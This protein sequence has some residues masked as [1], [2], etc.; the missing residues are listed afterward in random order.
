MLLPVA[1]PIDPGGPA[2]SVHAPYPEAI[3]P[4]HRVEPVSGHRSDD[5]P[6]VEI[7]IRHRTAGAPAGTAAQAGHDPRLARWAPVVEALGEAELAIVGFLRSMGVPASEAEDTARRVS[8]AAREQISAVPEAAPEHYEA[9]RLSLTLGDVHVGFGASEGQV[10]VGKAEIGIDEAPLPGSHRAASGASLGG[11]EAEIGGRRVAF[12]YKGPDQR[13]TPA[14]VDRGASGVAFTVQAPI[15][16][17]VR[18]GAAPAGH[19]DVAI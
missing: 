16:P 8:G 6:A 18:A 15:A 12:D 10:R 2:A 13:G 4:I 5:D 11:A 7:A 19:V 14:Y 17:P 1:A 3:H 9:G